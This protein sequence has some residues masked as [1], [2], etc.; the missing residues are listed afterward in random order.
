MLLTATDTRMAKKTSKRVFDHGPPAENR[1]AEL[2]VAYLRD[3][4]QAIRDELSKI[5]ATLSHLDELKR[6]SVMV[7]AQRKMGNAANEVML[8]RLKLER[9][10]MNLGPLE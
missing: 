3:R 8:F 6:T 10:T 9:A 2:T 4:V 5:E 7:D 1:R